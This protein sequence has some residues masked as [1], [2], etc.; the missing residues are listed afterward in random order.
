MR[1][2]WGKCSRPDCE[3]KQKPYS[4][5]CVDHYRELVERVIDEAREAGSLPTYDPYDPRDGGSDER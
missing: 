4:R 3:R 5:L 1:P 2:R